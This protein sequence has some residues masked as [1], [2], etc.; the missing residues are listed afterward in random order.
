M[1]KRVICLLILT[2]LAAGGYL[3]LPPLVLSK[4]SCAFCD[5]DVLHRQTFYQDEL[6]LALYTH[7]PILPGHCLIVPKKHIERF[8]DLSEEEAL[9]LAKVI[10]KSPPSSS[11]NLWDICLSPSSEKWC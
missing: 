10:K 5:S 4:E 11:K 8:E 7:K 3:L 6:A 9:Q 2:L 1:R